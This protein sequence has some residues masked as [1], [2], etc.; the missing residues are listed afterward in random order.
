VE[1]LFPEWVVEIE[2]GVKHKASGLADVYVS[3]LLFGFIPL[4]FV[5]RFLWACSSLFSFV[6]KMVIQ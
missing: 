6:I 5:I 1:A 2:Q 4:T 3:T